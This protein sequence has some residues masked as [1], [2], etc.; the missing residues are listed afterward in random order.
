MLD[1]C[2]I[3]QIVKDYNFLKGKKYRRKNYR[4]SFFIKQGK[5]KRQS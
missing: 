1:V 4:N 5:A 2:V 3:G